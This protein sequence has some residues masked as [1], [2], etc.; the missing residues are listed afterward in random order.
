MTLEKRKTIFTAA[1]ILLNVINVSWALLNLLEGMSIL[2]SM[3]YLLLR[4]VLLNG[5]ASVLWRSGELS[6]N[7][8]KKNSL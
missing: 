4:L 5:A 1:V 6:Q 8:E 3:L 2:I 7:P